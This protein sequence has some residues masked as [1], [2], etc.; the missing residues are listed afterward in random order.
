MTALSDALHRL[1][2]EHAGSVQRDQG[3]TYHQ[4]ASLLTQLRE[5]F[6]GISGQ[7][8]GG[9]GTPAPISL[10]AYDIYLRIE[11]VTT[12]K[13]WDT[14]QGGQRAT[15]E[16]KMQAW[17]RIASAQPDAEA[18]AEKYLTAWIRDIDAYF[19]PAKPL[20]IAG[21]CP[22]C[23]YSHYLVIEEGEHVRKP[24]LIGHATQAETWVECDYCHTRWEGDQMH[25]LITALNTPKKE[26]TQTG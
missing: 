23:G 21:E 17:V 14:H 20:I 9:G 19:K 13:Y 4:S 10:N 8:A 1:T 15:L 3:T 12:R 6:E 11:S 18:E 25:N 26:L 16:A 7:G 24:T 22:Q 2:R 5:A